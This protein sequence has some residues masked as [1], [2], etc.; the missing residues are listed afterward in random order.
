MLKH[1]ISTELNLTLWKYFT[2]DAANVRIRIFRMGGFSGL[3]VFVTQK[4][5]Q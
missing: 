1:N 5:K 3:E 2:E 4:L